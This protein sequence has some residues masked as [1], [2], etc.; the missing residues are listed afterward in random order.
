MLVDVCFSFSA[1]VGNIA[2]VGV[3]IFICQVA[4]SFDG[5]CRS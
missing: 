3:G 5:W 4:Y 2:D 1:K